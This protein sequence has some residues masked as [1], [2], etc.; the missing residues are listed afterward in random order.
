M[1]LT[2]KPPLLVF[3]KI[4]RIAL[5]CYDVFDFF[6]N[7]INCLVLFFVASLKICKILKNWEVIQKEKEGKFIDLKQIIIKNGQEDEKIKKGLP[8]MM[9]SQML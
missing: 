5:C 1:I 7:G 2:S 4:K 9:Y 3:Q 8:K 6:H